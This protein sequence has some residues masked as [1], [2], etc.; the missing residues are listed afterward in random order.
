MKVFRVLLAVAILVGT[1]DACTSIL[2]SRGA[3]KDGSVMITYS[4][5]GPFM[6]RL[7]HIPAADHKPGTMVEPRGGKTRSSA[8]R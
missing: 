2:V 3:S 7:L 5:D 8:G 1:A 4:A 6:P